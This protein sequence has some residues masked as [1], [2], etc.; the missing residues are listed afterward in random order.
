MKAARQSVTI[1]IVIMVITLILPAWKSSIAINGFLLFQ[2]IAQAQ[3]HNELYPVE[4]YNIYPEGE[5]EIISDPLEGYN[6]FMFKVNDRLYFWVFKP[7]GQ[8]YAKVVPEVARSGIRNAFYNFIFPVR[9][10]NNLLQ[11]KPVQAG[12]E[13]A[14]FVLNSLFGFAGFYNF[15]DE[16]CTAKLGPY[17]EDF[18]QTLGRYG[19]KPVLYIVWPVLGPSNLRDSIGLGGDYFLDPTF[20]MPIPWYTMGGIK[21]WQQVNAV[22]L[23][24]GEYED[25]LQS[26]IDPYISMRNAFT[27]FRQNLIKK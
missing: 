15:V 12:A 3:L 8:G 17:D 6:R 1:S 25:F 20:Y 24:L 26:A 16:Q 19:M 7:V 2:N 4:M 27:Q 22:S 18:G 13:A 5:E 21:T 23:R 14:R 11:L 9:F 10:V